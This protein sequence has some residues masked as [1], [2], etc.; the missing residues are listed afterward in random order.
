MS[1]PLCRVQDLVAIAIH[2]DV[3]SQF[4]IFR[5]IHPPAALMLDPVLIFLPYAVARP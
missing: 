4:L 5:E 3:T 2:L 1:K